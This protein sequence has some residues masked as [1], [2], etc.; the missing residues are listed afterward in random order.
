MTAS[1]S[2]M[3]DTATLNAIHKEIAPHTDAP[4]A[5]SWTLAGEGLWGCVFDLGDG[6]M[7]KVVR[8]HGGLGSGEALHHRESETLG[9]LGG[10]ATGYVRVPALAAG[11]IFTNSYI[12]SAPPLAGWLR[13]AAL[14][15]K[16]LTTDKVLTM[17]ASERDLLGERIG[18]AIV[19]FNAEAS[20]RA[21]AAGTRLA[22]T[23]TRSLTLAR[24]QLATA[25]LH[26]AADAI[27]QAWETLRA[28]GPLVFVH[29]DLN[30]GNLIDA[31]PRAPLGF[32]DFAES[33]WSLAEAEFRHLEPL[34]PFRDSIFRGVTAR[35]G[36]APNMRA[37]YL[38]A[39]ADALMTVA[40]QGNAGHPRDAMR[41]TGL[42]RHCLAG[43]EIGY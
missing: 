33:G 20:T 13:L 16:R 11:G 38:A 29:G 14:E 26:R 1:L 6:T 27:A 15:G 21:A 43:A 25:E 24:A 17:S 9:F 37:Y 2:R 30:P 3:F 31:G 40:I 23:I 7:L 10:F 22:D 36:Q 18:A 34:G 35:R 8:R 19:D 32:V 41:R 28:A 5:A 12:G 4:P 42:L 39:A